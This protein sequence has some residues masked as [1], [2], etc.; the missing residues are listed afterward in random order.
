MAGCSGA[1]GLT[2]CE[3]IS[4]MAIQSSVLRHICPSPYILVVEH[5]VV[6][7][8]RVRSRSDSIFNDTRLSRR[9]E[10]PSLPHSDMLNC[11]SRWVGS[12]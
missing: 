9:Y 12:I 6:D 2:G 4:C 5:L 8:V 3:Q 1:L 11:F 7:A 10:A